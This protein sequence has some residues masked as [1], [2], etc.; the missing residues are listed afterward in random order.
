MH[1][2]QLPELVDFANTST[3]NVS[4]YNEKCLVKE[5]AIA[6]VCQDIPFIAKY[7]PLLRLVHAA[8]FL[9]LINTEKL[10]WYSEQM[11]V[12]KSLL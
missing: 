5:F 6:T 10:C 4:L 12:R 9:Y 11:T 8:F 7:S 2:I 1:T 3:K